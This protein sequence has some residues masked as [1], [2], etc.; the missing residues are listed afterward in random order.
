MRRSPLSYAQE[1]EEEQEKARS[2]GRASGKVGMSCS[3]QEKEDV[4]KEDERE[5]GE[6]WERR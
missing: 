1:K 5:R 2:D 3:V 6:R 4:E